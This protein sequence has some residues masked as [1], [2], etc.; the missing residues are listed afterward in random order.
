[1]GGAELVRANETP[2]RHP[3]GFP[4]RGQ[5]NDVDLSSPTDNR[6]SPNSSRQPLAVESQSTLPPCI[7]R[8]S[9]LASANSAD[10]FEPESR[11]WAVILTSAGDNK[12]AIY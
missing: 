8:R 9:N 11:I 7:R 12:P 10:G 1:M 5:A 6:P 4:L 2:T 3:N